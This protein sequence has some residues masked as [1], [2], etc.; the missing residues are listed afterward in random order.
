MDC[1][2]HGIENWSFAFEAVRC[3]L[4]YLIEQIVEWRAMD[5]NLKNL[6]KLAKCQ[7]TTAIPTEFI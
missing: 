6:A 4:A 3:S 5:E 7:L 1:G 2:L